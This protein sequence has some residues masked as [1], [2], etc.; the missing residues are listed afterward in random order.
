MANETRNDLER[1]LAES[2]DLHVTKWEHYLEIYE[3]HLQRF[4][5]R[6]VNI[7][8][9]GVYQGGSLQMWKHYFG[10]KTRIFAIDIEPRCR[11]FEGDGVSIFIGSQ[12]DRAFLRQ[13]KQQIPPV[14]ILIDDGGH[15]M[16][17]QITT[18]EE[19]F[20]HI[21]SDGVYICEDLHTSYWLE[22]GGG[23]KRRGTLIEHGKDLIDRLNAHHSE[24]RSLAVDKFTRSVD[25]L[26]FYDSVLVIEK[27]A[28]TPPR[29]VGSGKKTFNAKAAPDRRL[30]T[31]AKYRALFVLNSGLR[32]LRL[33]SVRWG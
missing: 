1:Y 3:R 8:E 4:R 17:E 12:R 6:D 19:L 33:P 15:K 9:I 5:G 23:H 11:Q 14:D 10:P 2:A 24:Q 31:R 28:R 21:K 25:S 26:H 22:Y 27:R 7:L 30:V 29:R 32:R 16:S 18:F 13:V 20:D